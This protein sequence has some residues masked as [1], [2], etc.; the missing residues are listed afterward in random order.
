[1][2]WLRVGRVRTGDHGD[3]FGFLAARKTPAV[4]PA[5][6]RGEALAEVVV[7]ELFAT[8]AVSRITDDLFGTIGKLK[9]RR[10]D[11]IPP[12]TRKKKE[13]KPPVTTNGIAPS[14]PRRPRSAKVESE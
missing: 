8:I 4:E 9:P 13:R 2:N 12:P 3:D 5:D 1:M 11:G 14:Y 10:H 7:T 6:D